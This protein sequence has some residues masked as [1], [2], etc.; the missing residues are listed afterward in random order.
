MSISEALA[1]AEKVQPGQTWFTH[2]CHDVMHAE[3]EPTLPKGVRIAYDG[4]KIQL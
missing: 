2:L 3:V 4:L 1:L